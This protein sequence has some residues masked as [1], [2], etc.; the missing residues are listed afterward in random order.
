M[1][2]VI[3]RAKSAPELD[4]PWEDP[5]W[6]QAAEGVIATFT[7]RSTFR[8]DVRFRMLYDDKGLYYFA[9]RRTYRRGRQLDVGYLW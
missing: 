8:P 5:V 7:E 2:Y 3:V 1:E 9:G 4:A 6:Q